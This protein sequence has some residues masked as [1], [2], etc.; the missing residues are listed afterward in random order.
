MRSPWM[1]RRPARVIAVSRAIRDAMA[2]QGIET[3]RIR[4]VHDG[5]Q[6]PSEDALRPGELRR[7]ARVPRE[8]PLVG[9]VAALVPDKGHASFIRAAAK[10]LSKR[11]DARFAVFGEGSE[12]SRLEALIGELGVGER[13]ILAGYAP[14]AALSLADLDVFVHPSLREGLGT[15]CLEA[16]VAGVPVALTSA[17]GLAD[18]AGDVMPTVAPDDPAA[19][20][21]EILRLLDDPELKA[22]RSDVGRTRAHQFSVERLVDKTLDCYREALGP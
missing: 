3:S 18:I 7:R 8:A 16:M 19:L 2:S 15:A 22:R 6:V 1:W 10:V 11:P 14:D 20:S 13:V 5:V 17:G 4:V 21:V 12:R 9:A